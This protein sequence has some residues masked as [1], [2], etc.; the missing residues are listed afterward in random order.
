MVPSVVQMG[1]VD[2]QGDPQSLQSLRT[3]RRNR[4][5]AASARSEVGT[6]FPRVGCER[7]RTGGPTSE[8]TVAKRRGE[9]KVF[10]FR[11]CQPL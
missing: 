11:C 5:Q 6:H 1:G 3:A 4:A 9:Q 2:A 7:S 8:D 10:L